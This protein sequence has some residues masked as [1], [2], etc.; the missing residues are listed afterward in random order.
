[1][2]VTPCPAGLLNVALLAQL[3]AGQQPESFRFNPESF[4]VSVGVIERPAHVLE[5]VNQ[6][7]Q[8]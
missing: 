7:Q 2:A 1:M 4:L 3:V 5:L 8:A 6:V